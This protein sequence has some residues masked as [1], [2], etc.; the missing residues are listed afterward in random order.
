MCFN[1]KNDHNFKIVILD[2][3]DSMTDDAQCILKNNMRK[4]KKCQILFLI[5]NYIKQK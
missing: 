4:H 5:C 1:V 2:E 3:I